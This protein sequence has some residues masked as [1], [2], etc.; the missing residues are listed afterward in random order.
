[1]IKK[2]AVAGT[3]FAATGV[4]LGAMGAH[5]LK[6][7]IPAESLSS[8]ETGVRYQIYHSLALFIL[9]LL[10]E[11][12]SSALLRT[13]G[14][15]FITGILLFS[16]SIYLL[17]TKTISALENTMWIGPITPLGGLCF[18]AGWTCIL[19]HFIRSKT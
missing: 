10:Y 19:I 7:K 13:A 2:F 16:G 3:L 12:Y 18:I 6:D 14:Y 17:S 11:K 1:M 5:A 4:I 9:A 8:F 15:L